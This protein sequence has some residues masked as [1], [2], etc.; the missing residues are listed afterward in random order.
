MRIL[1]ERC[2]SA[3]AFAF[4]YKCSRRRAAANRTVTPNSSLLCFLLLAVAIGLS[5]STVQSIA[6]TFPDRGLKIVVPFA[7]GGGIDFVGRAL[8]QRLEIELKQSVVI[9]NRTS[10]GSTVGV[11]SVAN[12]PADGYTFLVVDPSVTI[13]PSLRQ[14][15]PYQLKQ[16]KVLATLTTAPLMV[17]VHPQ[18]PIHSLKE[19]IE[20]SKATP[21]GMTYGSAGIGTTTH[22][23]PELLKVQ[24][25]F[26]ATHIPYRGGGPSIPDLL[27]GRIHSVF[28]SNATV[29]PLMNDGRVRAVAQ[30][31][32]QRIKASPTVPTAKEAGY[33][34]FVVELWT[35]VFVPVGLPP[36]VEK[37]L[38]DAIKRVAESPE[39]IAAIQIGGLESFYKTGPTAASFVQAEYDRWS[40]LIKTANITE[41]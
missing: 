17:V 37:R 6:Q 13:N 24:T 4:S 11:A 5:L 9:E 26:N 32:P 27:S 22:L 8:G 41:N 19:M 10:G 29:L 33:P 36:S 23:A 40:A 7:P 38:E 31:G 30:T 21:G 14:N 35:A 25:G 20:Y 18:L 1:I 28:Y 15:S 34:D 2:A 3:V 16:L 12:A 39:F